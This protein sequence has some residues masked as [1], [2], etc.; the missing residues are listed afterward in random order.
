[1]PPCPERDNAL[2][3]LC[4][5]QK[6]FNCLLPAL[7]KQN[8]PPDGNKQNNGVTKASSAPLSVTLGSGI[9]RTNSSPHLTLPSREFEQ[10]LSFE[11]ECE[12]FRAPLESDSD[13]DDSSS[14]ADEPPNKKR[15]YNRNH[16][17][18]TRSRV[19]VP[20]SDLQPGGCVPQAFKNQGID[21]PYLDFYTNW[22]LEFLAHDRDWTIYLISQNQPI[23][24]FGTASESYA[25]WLTPDLGH[26]LFTCKIR[27]E[28][29]GLLD[30]EPPSQPSLRIGA[31]TRI[32][33]NFR[34]YLHTRGMD[35]KTIARLDADALARHKTAY[36]EAMKERKF[37]RDEGFKEQVADRNNRF[38]SKM[39]EAD[40]QSYSDQF[41]ILRKRGF[42]ANNFGATNFGA[43]QY[44]KPSYGLRTPL[45]QNF[46]SSDLPENLLSENNVPLRTWPEVVDFVK[47]Y[48]SD[49]AP[50]H[51][52]DPNF[53]SDTMVMRIQSQ[54]SVD[55]SAMAPGSTIAIVT[56]ETASYKGAMVLAVDPANPTAPP[57]V[58]DYV[59][60]DRDPENFSSS[61]VVLGTRFSIAAP[62]VVG[63]T[64]TVVGQ[65]SA[66]MAKTYIPGY[67]TVPGKMAP[68]AVGRNAPQFI[69]GAESHHLLDLP[70]DKPFVSRLKRTSQ[71][72]LNS[73][74]L[75][76]PNSASQGDRGIVR[77][78]IDNPFTIA[79]GRPANQGFST[80]AG[81]GIDMS[82]NYN[83]TATTEIWRWSTSTDYMT[84]LLYGDF[85]GF[86]NFITDGSASSAV[87][88]FNVEFT[89]S[90]GTTVDYDY[91]HEGAG[92]N[93]GTFFTTSLGNTNAEAKRGLMVKDIV[94]TA[95]VAGGTSNIKLNGFSFSFLEVPADEMYLSAVITSAIPAAKVL[96]NVRTD[97]EIRVDTFTTTGS[98]ISA[99]NDLPYL[100]SHYE[101]FLRLMHLQVNSEY[102][103][104][105]HASSFGRWLKKTGKYLWDHGGKQ[106]I[107]TGLRKGADKLIG[108]IAGAKGFGDSARARVKMYTAFPAI[109]EDRSAGYGAIFDVCAGRGP[110]PDFIKAI[111]DSPLTSTPEGARG[112]SADLAFLLSALKIEGW[113]VR[114]GL[115]VSGEIQDLEYFGNEVTFTVCP[116]RYD[117]EKMS[118]MDGKGVIASPLGF[119]KG[120]ALAEPRLGWFFGPSVTGTITKE[121]VSIPPESEF[122]KVLAEDENPAVE[123][124]YWHFSISKVS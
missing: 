104:E 44:Q 3:K 6:A 10:S 97:V 100:S 68:V 117:V 35:N 55:L 37:G 20:M 9:S 28:D 30:W 76:V 4:S 8:G 52:K 26:A 64:T 119:L 77:G 47:A 109:Y 14:S 78:R 65:M 84:K 41:Q 116:V 67:A 29:F 33:K 57:I 45:V 114:S 80:A 69:I 15:K 46:N 17:P 96:V 38:I 16:L 124:C 98:L 61:L 32:S 82:T 31:R 81:F 66:Q 71:N 89:Y 105:F 59:A 121:L 60:Q 39:P 49:D 107:D 63:G 54:K 40:R 12:R 122:A 19:P 79:T 108:K 91:I 111:T 42:V 25:I 18:Q 118:V 48:A 93:E 110:S 106:V 95:Y 27:P 43:E 13:E 34:A 113:P 90:D 24:R 11:D 75:A 2:A 72:R 58:L 87:I 120:T 74:V 88:R 36:I 56:P 23:A 53:G 21:I 94:I 73:D 70:A 51:P 101:N 1:M 115:V 99:T 62:L 83:V 5:A 103:N 50:L 112:S 86:L 102:S 123:A 85:E 92:Q 22:D 7:G